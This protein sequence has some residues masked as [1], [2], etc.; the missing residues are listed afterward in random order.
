MAHTTSEQQT[1]EL[2]IIVLAGG[3][4]TRM[5]SHIPKVLHHI[6]QQPL[7]KYVLEL[8][9]QIRAITQLEIDENL[10]AVNV[11]NLVLVVGEELK[12]SQQL[13]EMYD[14]YLFDIVVQHERLGTGDALR[15]AIE[16]IENRNSKRQQNLIN[17]QEKQRN[18]TKIVLVLYG[19]S[20]FITLDTVIKLIRNKCT[21]VIDEC[22]ILGQTATPSVVCTGFKANKTSCY[23]RLRTV[24]YD[25]WKRVVSIIEAEDD[26]ENRDELGVSLYNA[27]VVLVEYEVALGFTKNITRWATNAV[28]NYQH[29]NTIE[30]YLTHIVDYACEAGGVCS[31]VQISEEE[32]YGIN[33]IEQKA[34]AELIAQNLLRTKMQ[35]SGVTLIAPET[36]FL[37]A[38]TKIAQ[39]TI[40]EPYVCFGREVVIGQSCHIFPFSHI[41]GAV[42]GEQ[43]KIGPFARIRPHTEI[44]NNC[45]IGNFCELKNAHLKKGVTSGHVGYI[46]DA[47]IGENVN[48]G[49]GTVFC[50][51]DGKEKHVSKVGA[52]AFIGS[53]TS[54][55]SPITIGNSAFIGAGSVITTDVPTR[56]LAVC[57]A[58]QQNITQWKKIDIFSK[59]RSQA[60][61]VENAGD[62]QTQQVTPKEQSDDGIHRNKK[63]KHVSDKK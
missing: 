19:D 24:D 31:Y 15:V 13:G 34:A 9:T 53:N 17:C 41:E 27:G 22:T 57:R 43:V 8:T 18:V 50:N 20:P 51:F 45:R 21:N 25:S 49:A 2:C 35:R 7:L 37:S 62:P 32:A 52:Y 59:E 11:T 38:D 1:I 48:I 44:Q 36:V 42:I 26:I 60:I 58:K 33:T 16:H 29:K 3:K 56:T 14:E 6:A 46:G 47:V 10:Y 30:L 4:G 61:T 54:I 63:H 39:G 28:D 40:I 5:S 55:V 12:Q 23:G